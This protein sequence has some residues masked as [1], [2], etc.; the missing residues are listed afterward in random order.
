MK[1]EVRHLRQ[2][3]VVNRSKDQLNHSSAVNAREKKL[4]EELD[5]RSNGHAAEFKALRG[6]LLS[7]Q[8]T[9]NVV[10]FIFGRYAMRCESLLE[11]TLANR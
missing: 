5:T 2:E 8:D 4:M 6:K 3:H 7:A 11:G 1:D 9:R 10:R